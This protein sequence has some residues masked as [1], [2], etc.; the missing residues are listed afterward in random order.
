MET[1]TKENPSPSESVKT[2]VETPSQEELQVEVQEI[3]SDSNF[4]KIIKLIQII[5]KKKN[6]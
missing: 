5:W 6:N 1:Q 4:N 2:P 3:P